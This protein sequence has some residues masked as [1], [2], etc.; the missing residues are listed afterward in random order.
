[1]PVG[2][3]LGLQGRKLQHYLLLLQG[4]D[5]HEY[6]YAASGIQKHYK[7]NFPNTHAHAGSGPETKD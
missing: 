3:I 4:H 6:D 1:M 7:L 5:L 2:G